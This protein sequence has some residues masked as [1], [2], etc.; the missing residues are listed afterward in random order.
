MTEKGRE[1]G[2]QDMRAVIS[3]CLHTEFC[4]MAKNTAGSPDADSTPMVSPRDNVSLGELEPCGKH[5][6]KQLQ[7]VKSCAR[8][9]EK[10]V[11]VW[12]LI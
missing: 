6:C 10:P 1:V 8:D 2:S 4:W 11:S 3:W 9:R 12:D 7:P 5:T